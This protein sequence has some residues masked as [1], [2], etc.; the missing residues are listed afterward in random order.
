MILFL[1]AR[2]AAF[3]L[4]PLLYWKL[5][6]LNSVQAGLTAAL[7]LFAVPALSA[8][9]AS[10]SHNR[11][12]SDLAWN[13]PAA[14][15]FF[16]ILGFQAFLRDYF[17]V[18]ADD[19]LVIQALFNTD[20]GEAREFLLH[21]GPAILKH[22]GAWALSLAFF[23][24][25]LAASRRLLSPSRDRRRARVTAAVLAGLFLLLHVNPT[26]RR[27]D[28]L[29]YFPLR[30]ARWK[31]GLEE[32][33]RLQERMADLSSHPGLAR[34]RYA[35]EGQRT[36]V[37]ALGESTARADWSL[38]GY[39]RRTTPELEEL[40]GELTAFDD[41][42]TCYPGTVGSIREFL[43]PADRASPRAWM[44]QPDLLTIARRAGYKTFWLSNHGSRSGL[45]AVFAS[46][47][48]VAQ[49][50]N[51]GQSRNE[52]SFDEVLL[53]PLARAIADTAPRKF[54][55]LHM[56][57]GHPA[58]RYR[59]PRAFARFD[60]A[61]DEVK[62]R[63]REEGRSFWA[64]AQRDEYDDAM[65]YADHLLRRTIEMCRGGGAP[66]AWLFAP[67]HGEDV[68]HHTDFVGHNHRAREMW[69]VPLLIWRS[70]DFP[71][72]EVDEGKVTDRPYQLDRLDHTLLGLLG[73]RGAYYDERGDILSRG[74]APLPRRLGDLPY[75]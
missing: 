31:A 28:P 30:W 32:T 29:L 74:F 3:L 18:S 19:E 61:E 37:F 38:Y 53:A 50:T 34:V 66:A 58:A 63:L 22:V 56:L 6:W 39:S 70:G 36:V 59:Y 48:D 9:T 35:G 55:L 62:R 46:H 51:R 67:D 23:G 54:I 21:N 44:D 14:A 5:G 64:L 1:L 25:V 40:G 57:G 26:Q 42:I 52:G 43:T 24:A 11:A 71:A 2:T 7:G 41:V 65:L 27:D 4:V 69:E 20:P 8:W 47:A 33:V 72:G 45:L 15:T 12:R 16:L 49:F 60:G 73:V 13:L 68:A 17:G 10:R 75:P